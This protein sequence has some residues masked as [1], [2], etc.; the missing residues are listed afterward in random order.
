MPPK[1]KFTRAQ[2]QAAALAIVDKEGL[3][4]LSMRTLA[5]TLGT[6]PMTLYNYVRDRGDLDA[7]VVEAVMAEVRLPRDSGEWQRDVRAIVEATWRTVRRHPNVIPLVLTRRTLHE[8]T[9]D[10]AEAL[11]R[12]LARSG[13]S[14]VD[15]LV[16][17]R[18]VSG[19]VM[20]FAQAQLSDPLVPNEEHQDVARAQALP[21]DRFPRL[22]EIAGAAAR[23]GADK[24]F[25]AGL[26]IVM[27]GLVR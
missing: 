22:I 24:E 17:F 11:L 14:G 5:A 12:A 26:D 10:W 23:L 19:F 7:L 20:G 2:L 1:A 27:A 6:G 3:G 18:T 16:A 13:R 21:A 15:L 8:T 4:A 25:R 9:L